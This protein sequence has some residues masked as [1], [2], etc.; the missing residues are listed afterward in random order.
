MR[1]VDVG[2]C[3]DKRWCAHAL[4]CVQTSG[5]VRMQCADVP[6]HGAE[7]LVHGDEVHVHGAL[8]CLPCD[9][10]CVGRDDLPFF[11]HHFK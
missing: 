10:V 4:C 1:S 9:D 7:V 8:V 3:T 2:V 5:G 6:M 11:K